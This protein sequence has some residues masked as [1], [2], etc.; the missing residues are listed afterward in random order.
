M[1]DA[2]SSLMTCVMTRNDTAMALA[3][4]RIEAE[5]AMAEVIMRAAEN[6]EKMTPDHIGSNIDISI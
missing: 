6:I 2:I 1:I 5:K 3:K 4:S